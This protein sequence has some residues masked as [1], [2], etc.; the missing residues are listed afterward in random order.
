M[1]IL[2]TKE[3]TK[4]FGG[5][6]AV[7]NL[8]LEFAEEEI[9]G[10]IGPNGAGKTTFFNLL[11][12]FLEPT[13]GSATLEG[14]SIIGLNPYEIA[15]RG[16]VRTFQITSLFSNLTVEENVLTGR[17]LQTE[18]N[19][20]GALTRSRSYR[21]EET[22][23][24][25]KSTE[26]LDFMGLVDQRDTIAKNLAFGDQRNLE[27]AIALAVEPKVLL[28]DEPAAGVNPSETDKLI[29]CIRS[30]QQQFEI[31]LVIIDHNMRCIMN[32][33]DKVAVL[34]EGCKITE[35][36]P[37]TIANNEEVISIYLGSKDEYV[38]S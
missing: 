3:L 35:G 2:K 23:Q 15:Q 32:L 6:R 11:T 1:A 22:K 20:L 5:L 17:Y 9:F 30:I 12:G 18:G 29:N 24:K 25:R 37:Q 33:C 26:I 8:S 4:D 36:T 10:I 28:L 27:I 38:R 31:T 21:Q 13:H 19:M 16:L 14:K 7:D 34:N